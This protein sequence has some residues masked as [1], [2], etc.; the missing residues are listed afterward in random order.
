MKWGAY[1]QFDLPFTYRN[2]GNHYLIRFH[3]RRGNIFD[4]VAAVVV[5]FP[6]VLAVGVAS[7]LRTL[8]GSYGIGRGGCLATLFGRPIWPYP[9]AAL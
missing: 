8:G 5:P 1:S 9:N 3:N 6:L 2:N 7:G 4:G